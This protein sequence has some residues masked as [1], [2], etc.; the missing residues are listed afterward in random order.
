MQVI[1]LDEFRIFP[2]FFS[3]TSIFPN[4]KNNNC[5]NHGNNNVSL[6]DV[7]YCGRNL[8][9]LNKMSLFLFQNWEIFEITKTPQPTKH[10]FK[11]VTKQLGI[12]ALTLYVLQRSMWLF[13]VLY[14]LVSAT[15]VSFH[16]THRMYSKC[17]VGLTK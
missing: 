8:M 10:L 6:G 15:H 7:C 14:I 12:N 1:F 2:R 5:H 17:T 3:S 13:S 16:T 9:C 4:I 11:D